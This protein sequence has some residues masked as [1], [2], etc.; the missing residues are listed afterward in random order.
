MVAYVSLASIFFQIP[1]EHG[2]HSVTGHSV[3]YIPSHNRWHLAAIG[4]GIIYGVSGQMTKR[5][6]IPVMNYHVQI[7]FLGCIE[8]GIDDSLSLSVL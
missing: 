5:D 6:L 2:H 1:S 8:N 3:S 4:S 7:L